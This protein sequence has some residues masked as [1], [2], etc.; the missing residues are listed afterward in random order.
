MKPG[1]CGRNAYHVLQFSSDDLT[2]QHAQL[3]FRLGTFIRELKLELVSDFEGSAKLQV[4]HQ[5]DMLDISIEVVE[6][7]LLIFQPKVVR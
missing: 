3:R 5:T 1:C 6:P 2:L 7:A 4:P